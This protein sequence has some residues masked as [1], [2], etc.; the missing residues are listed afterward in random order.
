MLGF[1]FFRLRRLSRV[2]AELDIVTGEVVSPSWLLLFETLFIAITSGPVLEPA[3]VLLLNLLKQR[4][5]I[6]EFSHV[7]RLQL[8]NP[9]SVLTAK[10]FKQLVER[11][12]PWIRLG[13]IINLKR[14]SLCLTSQ[15]LNNS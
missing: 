14:G 1:A 6:L 9:R 5:R 10:F 8:S 3:S 12:F 13:E 2:G 11:N 7:K 15:S 4:L